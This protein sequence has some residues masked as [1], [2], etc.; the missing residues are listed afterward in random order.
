MAL[1]KVKINLGTEGNLSGS[2][3]IIQSTKTLVSSSAQIASNISGSITSVSSSTA[4]RVAANLASINTLNGSGTAQGVG[5]SDSPTFNDVT[6]TGTLTAQEVH[7][8]FESAS[9]LFTSGST[10]FGNSGDDIHNMTGS[11]RVSGSLANESFILGHN[12]GI[13]TNNPS[14]LLHLEFNDDSDVFTA[15][16]ITDNSVSGILINN[17]DTVNG[18]G[19]MLKFANKNGDNHTAI[20]HSQDGNTDAS[21][22]F[23]SMDG[24]T[25]AEVMRVDHTHAIGIGNSAPAASLHI[26]SSDGTQYSG[27]AEPRESMII[28]NPSGSDNTAVGLHSTLGFQVAD[29]ATSQGFINY[30]RTGN[31]TG[32][33]TFSQRTAS[34][35]YAE[36][37][38]IDSSGNVGIGKSSIDMARDGRTSLEIGAV[39]TLYSNTTSAQ[40]GITGLGHNYYYDSINQAKFMRANEEAATME[41]YNGGF[42]FYSDSRTDQ[43]ADA[44]A[45][46][47]SKLTILAN[48]NVGIGTNNPGYPLHIYSDTYPQL[49]IDGTDNSGNIGLVLSGS[50]G[51][52]GMRWNGSN[53]DVEILREGGA[54]EISLLDGGGATFAGSVTSN[55][56]FVTNEGNLRRLVSLTINDN[57]VNNVAQVNQKTVVVVIDDSAGGM[58]SMFFHVGGS[59]IAY[60]WHMFD[61]DSN[62][63]FENASTITSTGTNG[64]TYNFSFNTG[65]GYIRIQRTNGSLSYDIR[66]YQ[67]FE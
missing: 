45:S 66:L 16:R 58:S 31:N 64:N 39:G 51:R 5:T 19:G 65:N 63:W 30:V 35:T 4:T 14:N 38:R 36:H 52:G 49:S 8:E 57:N 33:F 15:A 59:G 13:G 54:V 61:T 6:V 20:A 56:G 43:S 60:N 2:R 26:G 50:G 62:T 67:L 11:I 3:S 40:G 37:M 12:L 44:N 10:Q 21:L 25:L 41:I 55:T 34:S 7:T 22:L 53:N 42:Y 1:T 46:V 32:E 17:L 24:G 47:T 29:G 28:Q 9:I 23:Y 48:G 18:H 27:T